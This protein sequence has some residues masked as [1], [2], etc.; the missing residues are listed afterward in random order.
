MLRI[1]RARLSDGADLFAL[2]SP[3]LHTFLLD[4]DPLVQ[5]ATLELLQELLPALNGDQVL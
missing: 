1:A 2:L 5:S 4:H 3:A